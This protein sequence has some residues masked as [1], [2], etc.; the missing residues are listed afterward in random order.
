MI[1]CGSNSRKNTGLSNSNNGVKIDARERFFV[2]SRGKQLLSRQWIPPRN[3]KATVVF[4]HGYAGHS[5]R[6][7]ALAR[8]LSRS[9]IAVFA[10][11]MEGHGG[12][13]GLRADVREFSYYVDDTIQFFHGVEEHFTDRPHYLVGHC[14]GALVAAEAAQRLNDSIAGI[15]M[16]APLF[17]FAREVPKVVQQTAS[18]VSALAA[19]F[20]IM[21]LDMER[22]SCDREVLHD[23]LNDP[24]TCTGKLRARMASHLI[25]GGKKALQFVRKAQKPTWIGH[26]TDDE[27]ADPR[28]VEELQ[29]EQLKNLSVQL[30]KEYR[31]FLLQDPGWERVADDMVKWIGQQNGKVTGP[32]LRISPNQTNGR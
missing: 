17:T 27:L 18:Y 3:V 24:L 10:F 7:D 30:Y 8:Y 23:F 9:G 31:H 14:M 5:G 20:P 1:I 11:D 13:E 16:S 4:L 25:E 28:T 6:Y 2:N 22:L 15:L 32:D 19:T 21:S 29:N 12:S 26:G